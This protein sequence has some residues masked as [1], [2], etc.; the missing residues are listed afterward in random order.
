[1]KYLISVLIC[2]SFVKFSKSSKGR[3]NLNCAASRFSVSLFLN[4]FY[5]NP[6]QR[7]GHPPHSVWNE[8][9]LKLTVEVKLIF[10]KLSIIVCLTVL[11]LPILFFRKSPL[12]ETCL[13]ACLETTNLKQDDGDNDN[14]PETKGDERLILWNFP[15]QRNFKGEK[16]C[17]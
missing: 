6:N 8:F 9:Q 1:L 5:L 11:G 14:E 17:E 4:T 7:D 13:L 12:G 3:R 16:W 15:L 10:F 2:V